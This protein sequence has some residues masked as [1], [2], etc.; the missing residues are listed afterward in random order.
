MEF[1]VNKSKVFEEF[2][3]KE[4]NR[5]V[6]IEELVEHIEK[7]KKD[8]NRYK[9]KMFCPECKFA[10]LTYV[11][12]TTIRRAHLKKIP[13]SKHSENCSYNYEYVHKKVLIE[14]IENL[15][16][17]QIQDKLNAIMNMLFVNENN[18]SKVNNKCI[19]SSEELINPNLIIDKTENHRNLKAIRRKKLKGWIDKSYETDLYLFY[20]E[21][22]LSVEEKFS[23]NNKNF[24][25]YILT[26]YTKN[27][28]GE[29]K[30]RATVY[31]HNTE[32]KIKEESIYYIVLM[33]R[34][35][36][37]YNY[38]RIDLINK[39]AIKYELI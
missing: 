38:P 25:F 24:K 5:I 27:K 18:K 6:D 9:G 15:N 30:F 19:K 32:D 10:E 34:L 36:F 11:N 21:V 17:N 2:F 1:M 3:Y 33:G 29:W 35:N 28:L 37:D 23:K 39:N 13:S 7:D 4:D 14:Y 8:I 16:Y 12:Q 20:G 22:K 26:L 31:R